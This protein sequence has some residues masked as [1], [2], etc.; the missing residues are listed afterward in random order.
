MIDEIMKRMMEKDEENVRQKK[1]ILAL[2]MKMAKMEALLK[3]VNFKN[4]I[5][6]N[7]SLFHFL[8]KIC[9]LVGQQDCQPNC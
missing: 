6:I 1:E 5:K 7:I 8:S 4:I 3:S 9:Q 2:K